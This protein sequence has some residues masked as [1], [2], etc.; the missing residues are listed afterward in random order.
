MLE[1]ERIKSLEYMILSICDQWGN[2][3]LH[4]IEIIV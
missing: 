1:S 2:V 4:Y 3:S